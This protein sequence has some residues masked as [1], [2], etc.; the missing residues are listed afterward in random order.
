MAEIAAGPAG[1]G[2][3]Q[4]PGAEGGVPG[5]AK[6]ARKLPRVCPGSRVAPAKPP[7]FCKECFGFAPKFFARARFESAAPKRFCGPKPLTPATR[8]YQM[9]PQ[10][11]GN[12]R[13]SQ[14]RKIQELIATKTKSDGRL[15]RTKNTREI[16]I[17]PGTRVPSP[18]KALV[19]QTVGI[20]I[21]KQVAFTVRKIRGSSR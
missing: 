5:N 4:L 15:A 10:K 12:A 6:F 9:K 11:S 2:G 13:R 21:I 7:G 18:T 3:S 16:T 1:R 8:I 20:S 14:M 17:I 19:L